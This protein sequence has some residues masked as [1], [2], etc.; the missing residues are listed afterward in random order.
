METARKA[1]GKYWEDN[2]QRYKEENDALVA[3]IHAYN[4]LTDAEEKANKKEVK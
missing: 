2:K 3:D 4:A 1:G